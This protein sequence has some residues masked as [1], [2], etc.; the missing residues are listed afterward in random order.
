MMAF[1]ASMLAKVTVIV[2]LALAGAWL[3]RRSRAASRH[4]LLAAAF[5][6]LLILP[7]VSLVAPSISVSVPI[8]APAAEE[9][10][11]IPSVEPLVDARPRHALESRAATTAPASPGA[12]WPSWPVLFAVIWT[13]GAILFLLPV[14]AGL[15]QVRSLRRSGVPWRRGRAIVNALA[16]DAGIRRRVAVLLSESMAGPVTCGL[17]RPAIVLPT[18]AQAW[19]VEDLRRAIVHELEHVRRGDWASHC[20]AR[21]LC[22]VYWFHPLVWIAWRQLALDAERA[23]DDAVL[24]QAEATAYADQ[25]VTL[26]Q[27]LSTAPHHPLL[28]MANRHDLATRVGAVLDTRQRRGRAGAAWIGCAAAA[29]TLLVAAISP[30]RI[31]AAAQATPASSV[32]QA[33]EVASIKPCAGEEPPPVGA[34]G[35][36]AGPGNAQTSPGR[37]H[38]DCVTL[39]QLI[40][41]AYAGVDNRLLNSFVQQRP[42]DPKLVRGGPSW[43]YSDKFTIDAKAAG[44]ADRSTLIGPMLRTLLEERFKIKTHR[45]TEER[46]LY[47]LTVAKSGL[48]I[49]PTA[50]T[51]CWVHDNEAQPTPPAG[52]ENLPS[53]GNMHMNWNGGNRTLTSTGVLLQNFATGTLSPLLGRYV[54]NRTS[55]EGRFNIPLEFAPDDN[56]PGGLS[57]LAWSRREGATPPT[58]P[59]IF[60]ALEELGLKLE[61]TKAPAEYLVIDRAERLSSS[62][63]DQPSSN[64]RSTF[65]VAS[66]KPKGPFQG[67]A[68][69]GVS[70]LPGGRVLAVN[71]PLYLLIQV[72]YGL[73]SRQVETKTV[74]DKL[75]NEVFDIEAKAGVNALPDTAPK[76]A[77]ERQ[78]QQMLQT[79]LAERFKLTLHKETRE[80]PVYA[81]VIAPGGSR[82]KASPPDRTCPAGTKC[83]QLGGGPA[84]GVRGL[85]VDMPELAETLT[86]FGD[87]HVVD[88]TGI[89]GKFD[90]DL[91]P[92][93][94]SSQG[95]SS[96]HNGLEPDED[97]NDPTIFAVLRRQLGLRLEP[98]RGPLEIHVVDHVERPTPN[99]R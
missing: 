2:A 65:E 29:C 14:I 34:G 86:M 89:K 11:P 91:P 59:S 78:L 18:E 33:F 74:D 8:A 21:A 49:K 58:A 96:A 76:D 64:G 39:D 5:A 46:T 19:P 42:G 44:A 20:L 66:V 93:N 56:T 26:A 25:L 27:R 41:T 94:R 32:S 51:E 70:L 97:P 55:I 88:R 82:L 60:K 45:A 40:N 36:S 9:E 4:V 53:C 68:E 28:A 38:W 72:A 15:S 16:A 6:V 98:T 73:S 35:R 24:G 12:T 85:D 3:A 22:A 71:A 54:I 87:R 7:I 67:P 83:G 17:V 13:L 69:I 61:T 37:V 47:A 79:L 75:M 57:G 77:R 1:L 30:L 90:I 23:C 43:V 95:F 99:G 63:G 10:Q 50:P 52:A 62:G 80:T 81:L 92:W 31:V 84:G 48:K